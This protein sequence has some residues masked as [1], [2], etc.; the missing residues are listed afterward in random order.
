MQSQTFWPLTSEARVTVLKA[1]FAYTERNQFQTN[2]NI[3]Q[4][5]YNHPFESIAKQPLNFEGASIR[6]ANAGKQSCERLW[7]T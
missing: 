6:P 3:S 5:N 2:Y 4:F 1:R 7:P